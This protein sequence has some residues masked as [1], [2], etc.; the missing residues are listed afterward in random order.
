MKRFILAVPFLA[1]VGCTSSATDSRPTIDELKPGLNMIDTSDPTWGVEAAYACLRRRV[2]PLGADRWMHADI[3]SA[4]ELVQKGR[5][6]EAVEGAVG[7]LS[8]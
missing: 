3:Q 8:V 5:L 7:P 2:E 1:A 6:V 4:I